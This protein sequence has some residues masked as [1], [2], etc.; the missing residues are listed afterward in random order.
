MTYTTKNAVT[1]LPDDKNGNTRALRM[2]E[3]EA[4]VLERLYDIG[5]SYERL[6]D[7][8]IELRERTAFDRLTHALLG[9]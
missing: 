5:Y 1:F 2:S 9:M 6:R 8:L 7:E 3:S 4:T